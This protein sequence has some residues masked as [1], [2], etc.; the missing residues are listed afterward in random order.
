MPY[1]YLTLE[2]QQGKKYAATRAG[3]CSII[4]RVKILLVPYAGA[5]HLE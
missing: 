3:I 1:C 5:D 2:V 4:V